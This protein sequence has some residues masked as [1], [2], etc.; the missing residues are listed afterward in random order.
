MGAPTCQQDF[1]K[2]DIDLRNSP[3]LKVMKQPIGNGIWESSF[4]IQIKDGN[5]LVASPGHFDLI[6][7]GVHSI[8]SHPTQSSS[9]VV[10]W[11]ELFT[12]PC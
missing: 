12:L 5:Y 7:Q 11:E 8:C 1:D 10:A 2:L 9:I 4:N 6:N 3:F